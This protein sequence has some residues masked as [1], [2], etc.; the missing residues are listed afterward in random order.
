MSEEQVRQAI[1]K[2]FPG[3]VTALTSGVHP[4]DKTT[5]L[6]LNVTDLLPHTGKAR[7]SYIFGYRS[8]K[9]IQVNVVWSS[10]GSTTADETI[11]GIANALRDYFATE[12]FRADSVVTNRQLAENTILVFRGN[13]DQKRTV[14]LVL[15]GVAASARSEEK[16]EPRRPPLTLELSYIENAAHPDVFKIGKGQF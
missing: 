16:K 3:A 1:R 15:G 7:I 2:D 8:K 6:S 10:D 11:V 14:L 9:L 12:N 13:D 4:S 5:I